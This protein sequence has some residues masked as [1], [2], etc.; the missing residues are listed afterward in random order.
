MYKIQTLKFTCIEQLTLMD[1]IVEIAI[2]MINQFSNLNL[3]NYFLMVTQQYNP[4]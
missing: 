2:I 3:M 4:G 1:L